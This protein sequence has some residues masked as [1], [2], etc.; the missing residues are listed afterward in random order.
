MVISM[1]SSQVEVS[2]HANVMA[3]KKEG[4]ADTERGGQAHDRSACETKWTT[5]PAL[6]NVT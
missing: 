6:K 2:E 5:R 1:T 3:G 4:G